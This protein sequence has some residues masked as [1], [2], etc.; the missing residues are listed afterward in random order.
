MT[1]WC[2]SHGLAGDVRV[3]AKKAARERW[4]RSRGIL[5]FQLFHSLDINIEEKVASRVS[6]SSS[7]ARAVP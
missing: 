2:R 5:R 7:G 1:S 6:A 3:R 4:Q